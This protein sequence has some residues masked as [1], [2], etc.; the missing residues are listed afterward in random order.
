M[1]TGLVAALNTVLVAALNLHL[2]AALIHLI[3]TLTL[4]GLC[5]TLIVLVAAFSLATALTFDSA[6]MELGTAYGLGPAFVVLMAGFLC[7]T[8][9]V[10]GT[11]LSLHGLIAAFLDDASFGTTLIHFGAAFGLSTSFVVFCS[12]FILA[13]ALI[14]LATTLILHVAF[15]L[16]TNF[17]RIANI[18]PVAV[19]V[20]SSVTPSDSPPIHSN[21]RYSIVERPE[22]AAPVVYPTAPVVVPTAPVVVPTA[23]AAATAPPRSL[24]TILRLRTSF[25]KLHHLLGHL[26]W[27][28]LLGD[29]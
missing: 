15:M 8:F 3:P 27:R 7:A 1:R 12:T 24:C 10:L 18:S 13:A 26:H 14:V 9:I 25:S 29:L 17:C 22:S 4:D 19:I 2:V 16:L 21:G 23:P 28:R 6:L 20:G 5:A 11:A